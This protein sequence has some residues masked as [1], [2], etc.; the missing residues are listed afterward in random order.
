MH[1]VDVRD[2]VGPLPG[3]EMRW[4]LHQWSLVDMTRQISCE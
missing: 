2:C 1:L 4:F 3:P